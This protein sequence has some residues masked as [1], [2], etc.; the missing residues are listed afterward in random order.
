VASL[1]FSQPVPTA[2][3]LSY[4]R[5]KSQSKP[6]LLL[7]AS[8]YGWPHVERMVRPQP[9][10]AQPGRLILIQRLVLKGLLPAAANLCWPIQNSEWPILH[11]A[12]HRLV[13]AVMALFSAQ[14]FPKLPQS[15]SSQLQTKAWCW[16]SCTIPTRGDSVPTRWQQGRGPWVAVSTLAWSPPPLP[17]PVKT[18]V[19]SC[20]K[21]G[22]GPDLREPT[23]SLC[24]KYLHWKLIVYWLSPHLGKTVYFHFE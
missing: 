3:Q 19:D 5:K 8:P 6:T 1:I 11:V 13:S 18:T 7:A 14:P 22:E 20:K 10:P 17:L 16:E 21:D 24:N 12:T 4:F 2:V 23:H 15:K 9:D